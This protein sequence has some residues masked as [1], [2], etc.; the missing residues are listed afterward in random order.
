MSRGVMATV[1][2]TISK[3]PQTVYINVRLILL[4]LDMISSI[5]LSTGRVQVYFQ[6]QSE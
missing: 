5:C 1:R 3:D 2:F 6:L 4:W